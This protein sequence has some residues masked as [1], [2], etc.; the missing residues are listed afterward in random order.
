MSEE[1]QQINEEKYDALH[2]DDFDALDEDDIDEVDEDD[3]IAQFHRKQ[4]VQKFGDPNNYV[5]LYPT[6]F[7]WNISYLPRAINV[8][9]DTQTSDS[10]VIPQLWKNLKGYNHQYEQNWFKYAEVTL[11]LVQPV[12]SSLKFLEKD[13]SSKTKCPICLDCF[14]F[15]DGI[16]KCHICKNEMYHIECLEKWIAPKSFF[17]KSNKKCALCRTKLVYD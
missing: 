10:D 16:V 1:K 12:L 14:N 15:G 8:K 4:L 5:W 7:N 9:L 17:V 3:V 2:Q 11:K 13:F 6:G